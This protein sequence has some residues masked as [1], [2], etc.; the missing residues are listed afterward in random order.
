MKARL[1][2]TIVKNFGCEISHLY[3]SL[4]EAGREGSLGRAGLRP[5]R[6]RCLRLIE[7]C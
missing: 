6:S 5:T 1:P 3:V 2:K 4:G 7:V